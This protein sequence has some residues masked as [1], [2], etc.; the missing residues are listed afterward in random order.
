M[1]FI[2]ERCLLAPMLCGLFVFVFFF[3]KKHEFYQGAM[4]AGTHA[5]R[6]FCFC[7]FLL[8]TLDKVLVTFIEYLKYF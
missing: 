4:F 2:K 7:F 1:N 5:M 3:K 8:L 6:S